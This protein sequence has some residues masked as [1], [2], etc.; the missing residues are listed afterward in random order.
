MNWLKQF[1]ISSDAIKELYKR[2]EPGVIENALLDQ[3]KLVEVIMFLQENGLKNLEQ[4]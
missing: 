1:G 3:E 2:Y 4:N